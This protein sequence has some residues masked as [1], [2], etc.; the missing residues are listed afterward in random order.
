MDNNWKVFFEEFADTVRSEQLPVK[1]PRFDLDLGELA[2]AAADWCHQYLK[3]RKCP[4]DL[5]VCLTQKVINE[6][7]V[8]WTVEPQSFGYRP[9][10]KD[11]Q[12]LWLMQQVIGKLNEI[13]LNYNPTLLELYHPSKSSVWWSSFIL[14]NARRSMEDYITVV[15]FLHTLFDI[16]GYAEAS[17]YA[18]YDG[19]NGHDAAVY[20]SMYLHQFLVQ[21]SYYPTNPENAFYD[22][23]FTTDKM[24]TQ[25]T[26]KYNLV[27]G[28][29]A[30]C[31]LYRPQEKKIYVAWVGDSLATLWKN[32]TP[33]SLVN[34]HVPQRNDENQRIRDEGGIITNYQGIYRVDGQLSVSRAIGDVRYKPHISAKP[35]MRAIVLDGN[36]E[37]LVLGSDGLWDHVD[38]EDVAD[39]I[40][41]E[42]LEAEGDPSEV[43]SKLA[44][45]AKAQG[46]KDNIS[47]ITVFLQDPK[48]L[49]ARRK[50]H[51]METAMEQR[52]SL[53]SSYGQDTS[54]FGPETDVDTPDEPIIG[55][56]K[57]KVPTDEGE[58]NESSEDSEDGGGWN[59]TNGNQR[60]SENDHSA[61]AE[62]MDRRLNPD[63][64][65]F[66]PVSSPPRADN[67]VNRFLGTNEE[68]ISSSPQKFR[69]TI[70]NEEVPDED[71]FASYV[72]AAD[73]SKLNNAYESKGEFNTING[74][75][76]LNEEPADELHEQVKR[77][78]A[79]SDLM[80]EN[81]QEPAVRNG[82]DFDEYRRIPFDQSTDGPVDMN[83]ARNLFDDVKTDNVE[84]SSVDADPYMSL[85][86]TVVPTKKDEFNP[87]AADKIQEELNASFSEN[88]SISIDS[89]VNGGYDDGAGADETEVNSRAG[90]D[91][92]STANAT[93]GSVI[94][95]FDE[96]D[97][98]TTEFFD[99][100]RTM[101]AG[102]YEDSKLDDS[103]STTDAVVGS[104]PCTPMRMVNQSTFESDNDDVEDQYVAGQRSEGDDKENDDPFS[105]DQTAVEDPEGIVP[106]AAP[107][108]ENPEVVEPAGESIGQSITGEPVPV[109]EPE[110]IKQEAK[111]VHS[112]Y[113]QQYLP[114]S[115]FTTSTHEALM[116]TTA[117]QDNDVDN[118]VSS[119][120]P[121]VDLVPHHAA[122]SEQEPETE[123]SDVDEV[124]CHAE[125]L[126][127]FR[128]DTDPVAENRDNDFE[129]KQDNLSDFQKHQ[130]HDDFA[131]QG[132]D[133]FGVSENHLN[134]IEQ[135]GD[136]FEQKQI[137]QS[138]ATHEDNGYEGDRPEEI[139]HQ[140]DH[141]EVVDSDEEMHSS[142]IIHSDVESNPPQPY[143]S[144]TNT[145]TADP[146]MM[147][148]S[149]TFEEN[150][151]NRNMSDSLYVM[152]TSSDYFGDLKETN[153]CPE[154]AVKE[155]KAVNEFKFNEELNV[156]DE[157]HF[158]KQPN[159]VDEPQFN[160]EPNVVD[161]FKFNE[162]PEVVDDFKFS[163][164]P[165]MVEKPTVVKEQVMNEVAVEK[166]AEEIV[167]E[168]KPEVIDEQ[169]MV[170]ATPTQL[171]VAL[172]EPKVV[173]P[174]EDSNKVSEI[175]VAAAAGVAVAAA[176]A[177]AV[178]LASKKSTTP[179]KPEA[180]TTKAKTT[181]MKAAPKPLASKPT[182]PAAIKRTSVST[183]AAK[184]KSATTST[185]SRSASATSRPNTGLKTTSATLK[186]TTITKTSSKP[187][188]PK[189][190]VAA[191]RPASAQKT[192]TTPRTSTTLKTSTTPKATT[193]PRTG[194]NVTRTPPTL[195]PTTSTT[196]PRTSL[197]SKPSLTN[198]TSRPPSRPI[199]AAA[200][201]PLTNGTAKLTNGDVSKPAPGKGRVNLA[202]R[203]SLAPPKL[204]AKAKPAPKPTVA[205]PAM[206][207]PIRRPIA[208]AT[209][210]TE[211][212]TS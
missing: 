164:E 17:F 10:K 163:E 194:V 117:G 19:H 29:T 27:S 62:D 45:K 137:E 53:S 123:D 47:V 86:E 167:I 96:E 149:M 106:I 155:S 157:P 103:A 91:S 187:V 74:I 186:P 100:N 69:E 126:D 125:G 147:S 154:Q 119:T 67:Y 140:E 179:K 109:V 175:V 5:I 105:F 193:S 181:T 28:T 99:G 116:N 107:A 71:D 7:R 206:P 87:F 200:K 75:K 81:D 199:S 136:V 49:A 93:V 66:V 204:P 197:A 83:R 203:T 43:C 46:S 138:E 162:E 22:A 73:L 84:P 16:K 24:F 205:P 112:V 114:E 151:Q 208:S 95:Q 63:A 2:G 161:E 210:K 122:Y 128:Y 104:E 178:A 60:Y 12:S 37:F 102:A 72:K 1:L 133:V 15:P 40:Y 70:D 139:A 180:T 169:P 76:P 77:D 115:D 89:K 79:P 198:G 25:K 113:E 33:L 146:D 51:I 56:S 9:E 211:T 135:R 65:E 143:C 38:T 55:L 182:A 85:M 23:F 134:S 54:G 78:V 188:A 13:C 156:I 121:E 34:K 150:F 61:E 18:V 183:T 132:H 36:E 142:M 88:G 160:E 172:E 111:A 3:D 110:F 190:T 185:T 26:E 144:T 174:Q 98:T 209:K 192:P 21:S 131:Q 195:K 31:V 97:V 212:A 191:P 177:G 189:T 118:G 52:N 127:Q 20:S 90:D 108:V 94:P 80:F 201:K 11:Y 207:G 58:V 168:P 176:A 170:E 171:A 82:D 129:L 165:K 48:Q 41:D 145:L 6:L 42:L 153:E 8:P 130:H 173:V 64:P 4:T 141:C 92:V 158:N 184:P 50:A 166:P 35:E 57:P 32:G 101:S 152:E 30:V 196:T 59:Y 159:I 44:F 202:T 120:V 124:K 14:K 68:F 148:R 39:T